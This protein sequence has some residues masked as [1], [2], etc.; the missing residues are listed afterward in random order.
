MMMKTGPAATL[1]MTKADFLLEI[2]I[3]TLDAPAQFGKINQA[4]ERSVFIQIG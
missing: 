3:V 1:V 4:A 2:E